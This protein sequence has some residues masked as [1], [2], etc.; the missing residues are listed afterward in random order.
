MLRKSLQ[1]DSSFNTMSDITQ[2]QSADIDIVATDS[3]N[4]IFNSLVDNTELISE[5][6]LDINADNVIAT[7][8]DSLLDINADNVV[9]TLQDSLLDNIQ[10]SQSSSAV[11]SKAQQQNSQSSVITK[12]SQI[13]SSS[14]TRRKR[15]KNSISI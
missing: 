2:S 6:L 10:S 15:K 14:R 9:A 5:S 8:Q 12:E 3:V 4:M 1:V 7:L 13:N 11:D